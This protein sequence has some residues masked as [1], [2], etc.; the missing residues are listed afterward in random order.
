MEV[1]GVDRSP[2]VPGASAFWLISRW[3]LAPGFRP[4]L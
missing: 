3:A 2:A 4:T 1:I